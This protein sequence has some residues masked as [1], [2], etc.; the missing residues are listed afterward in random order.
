ML[1]DYDECLCVW[2][3]LYWYSFV[4]GCKRDEKGVEK[5]AK[6]QPSIRTAS[7]TKVWTSKG[8]EKAKMLFYHV[9]LW[10]NNTRTFLHPFSWAQKFI[11]CLMWRLTLHTC[12]LKLLV[13]LL[14]QTVHGEIREKL[15]VKMLKRNELLKNMKNCVI[16]LMESST[17]LYCKYVTK[18]F[19]RFSHPWEY[20]M[21]LGSLNKHENFSLNIFYAFS[22]KNAKTFAFPDKNVTIFMSDQSETSYKYLFFNHIKM[23]KEKIEN[24]SFSCCA[25]EILMRNFSE[26]I[27]PWTELLSEEIFFRKLFEAKVKFLIFQ[28]SLRDFPM[29][30]GIFFCIWKRT[31]I[32]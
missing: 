11:V 26:F 20:F 5:V 31:W 29:R 13:Y 1:R 7:N 15:S 27:F 28:T 2:F 23:P 24:F 12:E 22:V 10:F 3:W 6:P 17:P 16:C 8:V 32:T 25:W 9:K 30:N 14:S 21:L 4:F 18:I 19:P